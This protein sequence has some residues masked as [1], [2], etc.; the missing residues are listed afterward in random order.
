MRWDDGICWHLEQVEA[1]DL[2]DGDTL[3]LAFIR[4][5]F[6]RGVNGA[7]EDDYLTRVRKVSYRAAER[8]TW[9]AHLPQTWAWVGDG[10]PRC[11]DG[12]IVL[13]KPPLQ[14]VTSI[15]YIDEDGTEQ[16]L[17]GSPEEFQVVAPSGE[18]AAKGYVRPLYNEAWPSTRRMPEA[19]RVEFVCG[20][21][22]V[23]SPAVADVPEDIDHGRL[24]LIGE[25]YKNRSES[26]S[27]LNPAFMRAKDIWLEY[28]AW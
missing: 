19:V 2:A 23:G 13:P 5:D 17:L 27:G 10:F 3:S 21:P 26:V 24:L 18:K 7:A 6:L 20:Y 25:M 16:T 28:R 15:T 12:R 4:D 8:G 14:S 9:R 1:P 22:L 11:G